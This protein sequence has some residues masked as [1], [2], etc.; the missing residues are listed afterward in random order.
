MAN[1][2]DTVNKDTF[3]S[4]DGSFVKS[5]SANLIY[6]ND[7]FFTRCKELTSDRLLYE[8][9]RDRFIQSIVYG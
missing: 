7:Y 5:P 4:I 2:W 6:T 3:V 1:N 9:L 8:F